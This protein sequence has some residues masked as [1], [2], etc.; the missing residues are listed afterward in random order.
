MTG[1]SGRSGSS[2]RECAGSAGVCYCRLRGC[3]GTRYAGSAARIG[4]GMNK[5][6]IGT[7]RR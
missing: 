7:G 5:T 2:W 6:G 3:A 4:N 1:G